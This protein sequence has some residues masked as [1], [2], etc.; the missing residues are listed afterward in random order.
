[1]ERQPPSP[2]HTQLWEARPLQ[3]PNSAEVLL[4]SRMCFVSEL[5]EPSLTAPWLPRQGHRPCSPKQGTR[6]EEGST[7]SKECTKRFK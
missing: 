4:S 5:P 2:M 6:Q 1:M 7:G 3:H